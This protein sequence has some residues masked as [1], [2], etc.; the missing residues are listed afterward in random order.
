MLDPE[1]R[2]SCITFGAPPVVTV[3]LLER[4]MIGNSSGV[5]LNIINE[6]DPVTR[7]DGS[8]KQCLVDLIHSIYKQRPAL[9]RSEPSSTTVDSLLTDD[10]ERFSKGKD[11]SVLPS[12]Y[13]HVGPRIV[14]LLRLKTSLKESSL[15]LRAVEVPRA[16]FDRLLFCR[17]AVHRRVCY[18]E[19]VEL[20][21]EGEFNGRTSW[22]DTKYQ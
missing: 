15:R 17:V 13:S 10:S 5:C 11:W 18:G 16:D 3:P 22:Y 7:A 12:C 4:P 14:L 2:F 6:F 8:Y 19:R 21:T 20:I 1:T 9:P